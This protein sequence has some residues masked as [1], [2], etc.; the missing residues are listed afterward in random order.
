MRNQQAT[1][2]CSL[3]KNLCFLQ[4]LTGILFLTENSAR[5]A[6]SGIS[7]NILIVL[8]FAGSKYVL[9]H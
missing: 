2:A 6:S 1:W 9:T 5:N 3:Q 8:T 4:Q 7:E